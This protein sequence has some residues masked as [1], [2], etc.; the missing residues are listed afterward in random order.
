MRPCGVVVL[1]PCGD[2]LAGL[3]EREEQASHSAARPVLGLLAALLA[4]IPNIGPIIA[5]VPAVL[6]GFSE[7]RTTMLLVIGVYAP[8]QAL[9]S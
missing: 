9:E 7:C 8:V 6:L 2:H 5:A 3:I 4:S 1:D